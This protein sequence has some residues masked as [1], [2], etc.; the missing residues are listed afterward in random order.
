MDDLVLVG[1]LSIAGLYAAT[2]LL[3]AVMLLILLQLLHAALAGDWA[4][5]TAILAAVLIAG[6]AYMATALWLQKSGRI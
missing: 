3:I 1:T 5:F 6:S 2:I 4:V